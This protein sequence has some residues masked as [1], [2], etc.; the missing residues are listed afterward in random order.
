[1]EAS[2]KLHTPVTL[3]HKK[4]FQ[5]R[6]LDM[7]HSWSENNVKRKISSPASNQIPVLQP[8]ACHFIDRPT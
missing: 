7:T 4:V 2:G 1:M 6:R 8:R 5:Y 3:T